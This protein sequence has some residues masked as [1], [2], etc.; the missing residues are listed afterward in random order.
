MENALTLRRRGARARDE[1]GADRRT[2]Q[3][4]ITFITATL[5]ASMAV[6]MVGSG[7]GA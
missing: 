7:T 6:L 5:I 3:R 1:R 4:A 2:G